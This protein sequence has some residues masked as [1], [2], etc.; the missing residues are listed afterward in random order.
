MTA[1]RSSFLRYSNSITK[2]TSQYFLPANLPFRKLIYSTYSSSMVPNDAISPWT[3]STFQ[4]VFNKNQQSCCC[5]IS[6][7]SMQSLI[8]GSILAYL[9]HFHWYFFTFISQL[10]PISYISIPFL[11]AKLFLIITCSL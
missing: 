5:V 2:T 9:H 3:F 6:T 4:F 8:I 1:I 11:C 10:S 7:N